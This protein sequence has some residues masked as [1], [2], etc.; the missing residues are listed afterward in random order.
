[1][2]RILKLDFQDSF[3]DKLYKHFVSVLLEQKDSDAPIWLK[4]FNKSSASLDG[5]V[6]TIIHK[7][8]IACAAWIRIADQIIEIDYIASH[9]IFRKMGFAKLLLEGLIQESKSNQIKAIWLEVNEANKPAI[10]LY[11]SMGFKKQTVR[12]N[13]YGLNKH[14]INYS[15]E[16]NDSKNS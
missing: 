7:D 2:E 9:P 11:E 5:D 16:I 13:Y 6:R 15:L 14:A 4:S 12:Q 1:M 10:K 3:Q 8:S